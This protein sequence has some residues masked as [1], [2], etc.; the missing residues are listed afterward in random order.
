MNQPLHHG[1]NSISK[2]VGHET[3]QKEY[4]VILEWNHIQ[5]YQDQGVK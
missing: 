3:F 5:F 4:S 1:I 2:K